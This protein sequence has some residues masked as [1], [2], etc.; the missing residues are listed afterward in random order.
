MDFRDSDEELRF[1]LAARKWLEV[2]M[3]DVPDL[4][5][6][7]QNLRDH[8][9]T[10]W[11][12]RLS[13]GDWVGIAWPEEY[14][15][16][17]LDLNFQAIFNEEAA[18]L[19]TPYPINGAGMALAGPTIL[20][21]GNE[22]TK[23][24]FLPAILSSEE[25]W[26][27]GFSEPGSGSDLASLST[28]ATKVDG[29]W[30]IN[31]SKIWTSWAHHANRC[32]LLARTDSSAT[33]HRGITYF[34]ASMEKI[35]VR[36][37]T[38]I[39]GDSE[40]NQMFLDDVFVSDDDVLGD[41]NSGWDVA[42]TTLAFERGSMALNLWVWARQAL[43]S[44]IAVAKSRDLASDPA[45]IDLIGLLHTDAEAIRVGSLRTMSEIQSGGDPGP[46]SSS[47]KLLWTWTMQQTTRSAV[48]LAG[49]EGLRL[50]EL[51]PLHRI[52]RYLRARAHSIEGG[53]DEIQKS[54]L[55]ER[56]LQLPRSR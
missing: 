56:V 38:M 11:Q 13:E 37:L 31:G 39:N 49:A 34:L 26:C 44:L 36:P 24:R 33:R 9:S 47:L 27:Q 40:F 5:G 18:R 32:M 23:A 51:E 42:L 14:G 10:V 25:I 54:I 46:E 30:V 15:G 52:N 6:S 41:V 55:A 19:D 12:Q 8:W 45:V 28:T 21:H 22:A 29:G 17:G 35:E 3:N 2:A 53:S 43:D 1:R 16:R 20:V 48:Q 50:D 7:P 4:R